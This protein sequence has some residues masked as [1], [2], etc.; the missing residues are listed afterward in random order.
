M[1]IPHAQVIIGNSAAAS[2]Q[3]EGELHRLEAEVA[4]QRLEVGLAFLGSVL[5]GFDDGFAL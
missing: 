2:E 5:K 4:F 3:L 1:G